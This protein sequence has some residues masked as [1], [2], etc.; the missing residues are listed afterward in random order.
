MFHSTPNPHP[1]RKPDSL[2]MTVSKVLASFPNIE[3]LKFHEQKL[4]Y[5][6]LFLAFCSRFGKAITINKILDIT[7]KLNPV[8][9]VVDAGFNLLFSYSGVSYSSIITLK[10]AAIERFYIVDSTPPVSTNKITENEIRWK[11]QYEIDINYVIAHLDQDLARHCA[12]LAQQISLPKQ[13]ITTQLKP[14]LDT[15]LHLLY[16]PSESPE[17]L[18]LITFCYPTAPSIRRIEAIFDRLAHAISRGELVPRA[19]LEPTFAP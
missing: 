1:V 3:K 5:K 12:I 10:I 14:F 16:S 9:Y 15:Y 17:F 7:I 18:H 4:L 6:N 13:V 11:Q 2:F 19:G 8:I